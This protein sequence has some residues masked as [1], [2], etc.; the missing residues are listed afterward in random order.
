[1][2]GVFYILLLIYT[3]FFIQEPARYD[4]DHPQDIDRSTFIRGATNP[5]KFLGK[6]CKFPLIAYLSLLSLLMAVVECGIMSSLFAYIGNEYKL[7]DEGSS[8][9]TYAIYAVIMSI[10]VILSGI[11]LAFF[12]KSYD[13]LSIM[14]IA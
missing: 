9:L 8:T 10:A 1:M 6:I 11:F 3:K 12:K 14:I 4:H 5:F 7:H 13:E 2:G